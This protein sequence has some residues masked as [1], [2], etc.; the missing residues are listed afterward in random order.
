MLHININL[1]VPC[2]FIMSII[3]F[4]FKNNKG[5]RLM[6]YMNIRP[7]PQNNHLPVILGRIRIL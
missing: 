1:I 4:F 6:F 3:K 2:K 7:P 5:I